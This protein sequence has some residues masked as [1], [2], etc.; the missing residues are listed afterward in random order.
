VARRVCDLENLVNEEAISRVGLQRHV[1]KY[2]I[3][4]SS[5]KHKIKNIKSKHTRFR[6]I[7]VLT[8]VLAKC[9][10]FLQLLQ[11]F[12]TMLSYIGHGRLLDI[13]SSNSAAGH[14]FKK[15]IYSFLNYSKE[16]LDLGPL[17]SI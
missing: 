9:Y 8:S 16:N 17:Y 3:S 13:F 6:G 7:P 4:I 2:Q 10:F 15:V 11:T 12:D 5:S 14:F 1:K